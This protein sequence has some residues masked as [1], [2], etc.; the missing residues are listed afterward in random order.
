MG[1]AVAW[2]R[3]FGRIRRTAP[4]VAAAIAAAQRHATGT[5]APLPLGRGELRFGRRTYVM[6]ILNVTPDSFSDGGRFLEPRAAVRQALHMADEGADLIDV[7]G[8]S[9]RPGS[10]PVG[11]QEELRRVLPVLEALIPTLRRRPDGGPVLSIDTTRS[12]TARR[13][14][15]LGVGLI[16]DISGMTFD[17]AMPAVAAEYGLP[18]VLQ[19]VRGRPASMQRAPRYSHLLAEIAAFLRAGIEK[20]ARAGVPAD[21]IVIDPGLGFGKTRRHNLEIL[22]HLAVLRSLGRPILIGASRKSFL[23]GA[24]ERPPTDR[25]E[26]S[27]AA[28]TLAIAGGA[29]IIRAHDVRETVRVARLCDAVVRGPSGTR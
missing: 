20:A 29:D 21:R 25:L 8:E 4:K 10:S 24:Q 27:L 13:A 18:V 17:P 2:R 3:F 22:R 14:A 5:P 26:G 19:H 15:A 9:T 28:E 6:G 11:L 7:G 16:N 1:S 23:G 12:E